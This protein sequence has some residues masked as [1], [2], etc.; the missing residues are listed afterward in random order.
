M[1]SLII[2]VAWGAA[3][4]VSARIGDGSILSIGKTFLTMFV[5]PLVSITLVIEF[6]HRNKYIGRY[7]LLAVIGNITLAVIA[8]L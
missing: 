5:I 3:E 8:H 2:L 7:L 1:F 6:L 4:Q